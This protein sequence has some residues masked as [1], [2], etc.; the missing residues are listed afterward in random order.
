MATAFSCFS[1]IF[2]EYDTHL[3]CKFYVERHNQY[4]QMEIEFLKFMNWTVE[5]DLWPLSSKEW[6][7]LQPKKFNFIRNIQ[8]EIR[9]NLSWL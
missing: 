7:S 1:F 3:Q 2:V 5:H 9:L 8:Y 4:E 6:D